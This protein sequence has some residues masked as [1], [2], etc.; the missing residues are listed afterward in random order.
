MALTKEEKRKRSIREQIL[1]IYKIAANYYYA[2][3]N[4]ERGKEAKQ[5]LLGRQLSEETIRHFGL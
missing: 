2:K 3:L 4:S 5:Y 1:E